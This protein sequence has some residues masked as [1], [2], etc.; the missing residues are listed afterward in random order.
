MRMMMLWL[1]F[2][3]GMVNTK[4]NGL[5]NALVRVTRVISLIS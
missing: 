5:N 1:R 3:D 2:F 4:V